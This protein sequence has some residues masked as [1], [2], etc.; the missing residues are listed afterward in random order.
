[1]VVC[2]LPSHA[3]VPTTIHEIRCGFG[4]IDWVKQD[5]KLEFQQR[6]V[7]EMVL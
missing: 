5:D 4:R 6:L 3:R 2:H 1:L 7:P